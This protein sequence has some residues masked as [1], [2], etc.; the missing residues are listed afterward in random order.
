MDDDMAT[1]LVLVSL[2]RVTFLR[3]RMEAAVRQIVAGKANEARWTLDAALEETDV[4]K[5]KVWQPGG[6]AVLNA[7]A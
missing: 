2:D 7:Q 1:E 4:G 3:E 5:M 6:R